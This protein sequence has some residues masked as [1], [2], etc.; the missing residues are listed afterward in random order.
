[1]NAQHHLVHWILRERPAS[2]REA[3]R[4]DTEKERCS[5]QEDKR[6]MN[7]IL[8]PRDLKKVLGSNFK[9]SAVEVKLLLALCQ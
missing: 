6:R 8:G 1:M 7:P 2:L 5:R 3:L 4:P 9:P